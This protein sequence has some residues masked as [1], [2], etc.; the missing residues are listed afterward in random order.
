[1]G[2]KASTPANSGHQS[3]RTRTF[4]SS[5]STEVTTSNTS[6]PGNTAGFNVLRALPG[7]QVP[8]NDRQ[9]ARSLSSVPDLHQSGGGGGV[10]GNNNNG[11]NHHHHHHHH[12]HL[13]GHNDRSTL[14]N[15]G[16]SSSTAV[17]VSSGTSS[18]TVGPGD[19]IIYGGHSILL[20]GGTTT[21][22]AI[23]LEQVE[24]AGIVDGIAASVAAAASASNS[25]MGRVYTATSLPSHIWSLNGIK[26]PVCSKFVLPDDIECH[27]VM[28][29]TKPRLSYNEDVLTDAKGECVI[30][31]EELNPGDV[32]AR[33]PC[34]CVYHKGCIDRWFEVNRSCPEHPGD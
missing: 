34:L 15:R 28:C 30:C 7:I 25:A 29:L 9:R 18:T 17:V 3:P 31:L 6:P 23:S 32:I 4:S 13:V 12:P 21:G 11:H 16:G 33:L 5:S 27:L 20:N 2:A 22:G 8:Q 1:M 10:V 24:E 19:R 14:I 26:C